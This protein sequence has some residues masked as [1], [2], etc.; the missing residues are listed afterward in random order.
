VHEVEAGAVVHEF[1]IVRVDGEAS[2]LDL[3]QVDAHAPHDEE[4]DMGPDV[5][6]VE[7]LIVVVKADVLLASVP[8]G[9]DEGEG[10]SGILGEDGIAEEGGGA[11]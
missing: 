4:I 11:F 1:S 9:E 7:I 5:L 8:A 2:I 10:G 6:F 3:S